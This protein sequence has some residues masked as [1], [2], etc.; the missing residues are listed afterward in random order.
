MRQHIFLSFET[1]QPL[2]IKRSCLGLEMVDCPKCG[3]EVAKPDKKLENSFF[4]IAIYT[5][6]GCG[7]TFK[8]VR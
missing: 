8:V 3:K 7:T 1:A 4:Q 6:E 5:C 2:F